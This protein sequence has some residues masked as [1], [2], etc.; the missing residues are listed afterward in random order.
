[1]TTPHWN[2]FQF[3]IGEWQGVGGGSP[4]QGG[5]RMAFRFDLQQQVLLRTSHMDFTATPDRPA[6][7]HDDLTVIYPPPAGVLRATYFDNEGHIIQYVVTTEN[8][9]I[10][11]LSDPVPGQPRFRTTYLKRP[12]GKVL[13]RFEI[14]NSG[15]EKDFSVYVEGLSSRV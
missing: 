3:L 9:G 6:F 8:D 12:Q 14:S 13:T 1:M 15:D 5:G 4:G 10:V 2:A 11:F 7:S